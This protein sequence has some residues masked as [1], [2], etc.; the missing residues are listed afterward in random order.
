[1]DE[2]EKTHTKLSKNARE[3]FED[4][5]RAT[6]S[7]EDLRNAPS[8]EEFDRRFSELPPNQQRCL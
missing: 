1:M 3:W 6:R 7:A 5:Q 4:F 2:V 8:E